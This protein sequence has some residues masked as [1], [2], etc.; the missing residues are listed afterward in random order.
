MASVEE[1]Q[2]N[3]VIMVG[4]VLLIR[5]QYLLYRALFVR[6]KQAL[7]ARDT[8]VYYANDCSS[9]QYTV[10]SQPSDPRMPALDRMRSPSHSTLYEVGGQHRILSNGVLNGALISTFH[11]VPPSRV[12]T[13]RMRRFTRRFH[14]SH[15]QRI[16]A[17]KATAT[18]SRVSPN[19]QRRTTQTPHPRYSS[20]NNARVLCTIPICAARTREVTPTHRYPPSSRPRPP[21]W[22]TRAAQ[23]PMGA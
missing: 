10:Q 13:A 1:K 23:T 5:R 16:V 19:V 14:F 3:G 12:R 2:C 8:A 4:D 15:A 11:P 6:N 7:A 18:P 9:K 17:T 20:T 22:P 21:S